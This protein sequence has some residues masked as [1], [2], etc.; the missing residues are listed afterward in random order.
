[1]LPPEVLTI[2]DM[3]SQGKFYARLRFNSFGFKW[4]EELDLRGKT[5][6]KDHSIAALGGSLIYK[7]AYLNGLAFTLAGYTTQ[8]RGSLS[9][10]EA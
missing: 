8:S 7:S 1:M 9:S 2:N 4:A 3:F 6:R 5:L 10:E